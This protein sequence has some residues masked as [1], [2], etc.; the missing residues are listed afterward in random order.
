MRRG[1]QHAALPPRARA[2]AALAAAARAPAA[3][4]AHAAAAL[5]LAAALAPAPPVQPC[6]W[7]CEV[8]QTFPGDNEKTALEK[9][10]EWCHDEAWWTH[11]SEAPHIEACEIYRPPQLPPQPLAAAQPAAAARRALAPPPP[12]PPPNPPPPPPPPSPP[13]PWT[14]AFG[15]TGIFGRRLQSLSTTITCSEGT[16]PDEIGW[17]LTCDSL[18]VLSGGA[19]YTSS[20]QHTFTSGANVHPGH[21]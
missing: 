9:A 5:A 20:V 17:T 15:L 11:A 3:A 7:I 13:P 4:A 16:Y 19:P 2:P 8:F 18:Y 1:A 10:H 14:D 21:D 6:K 12:A